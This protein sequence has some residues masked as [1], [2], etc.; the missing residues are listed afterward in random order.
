MAGVRLGITS[1]WHHAREGRMLV[2][3][4]SDRQFLAHGRA[5]GVDR[6]RAAEAFSLTL[7]SLH[8]TTFVI[9]EESVTAPYYNSGLLFNSRAV[10]IN[11]STTM[12]NR[13][14]SLRMIRA[15]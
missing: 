1:L 6:H 9:A 7:N 3:L 8:N 15:A 13:G 12:F 14:L 2:H 10:S 11:L 4:A 5:N